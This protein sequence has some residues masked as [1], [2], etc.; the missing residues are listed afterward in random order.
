MNDTLLG[1]GGSVSFVFSPM[2]L[3]MQLMTS[4]CVLALSSDRVFDNPLLRF[5]WMDMFRSAG[6]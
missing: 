3:W 5:P 2:L 4:L 1:L 6:S